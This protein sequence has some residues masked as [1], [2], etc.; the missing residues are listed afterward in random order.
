MVLIAKSDEDVVTCFPVLQELRPH[1]VRETFLKT[2]RK[3][4]SEGFVLAYWEHDAETVAV[5]GFRICINLA[6]EGNALYVYDLVTSREHRGKGFGTTMLAE[7]KQF[8][9][10]ADCK[11]VHLDSNVIRHGAHKFYFRNGFSIVAHHFLAKV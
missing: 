6:A 10:D 4:Q 11:V 3:M 2:V 9:R 1:L 5:A 7:I 8:A